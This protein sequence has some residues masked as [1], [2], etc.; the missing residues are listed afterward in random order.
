MGVKL[1]HEFL[2]C[3]IKECPSFKNADQDKCWTVPGTRCKDPLTGNNRRKSIDEK[4]AHCYGDCKYHE[5]RKE[6]GR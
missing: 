1:C 6:I 3:R 5:Y 4:L 2:R